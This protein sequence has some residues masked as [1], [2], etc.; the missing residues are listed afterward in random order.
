M[1][2]III[3]T[4]ELQETC[5]TLA[6]ENFDKQ[7]GE[8]TFDIGLNSTGTGEPSHFWACFVPSEEIGLQIEAMAESLGDG[9]KVYKDKSPQDILLETG[10]KVVNSEITN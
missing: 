3:V 4:K 2:Y 8:H 6:K 9:V 10:L 1:K 7:G 5:N